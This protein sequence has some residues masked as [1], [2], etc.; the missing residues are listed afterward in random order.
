M[1]NP[2]PALSDFYPKPLPVLHPLPQHSIKSVKSVDS[3]AS[4]PGCEA[5]LCLFSAYWFRRQ[6]T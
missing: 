2:L 3:E 1:L 6:I 4:L 5:Q